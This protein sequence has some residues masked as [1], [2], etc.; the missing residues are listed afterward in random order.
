MLLKIACNKPE[1]LRSAAAHPVALA[2]DERPTTIAQN[3]LLHS[4]EKLDCGS[5]LPYQLLHLCFTQCEQ[6]CAT[7]SVRS[8]YCSALIRSSLIYKPPLCNERQKLAVSS[9]FSVLN[10]SFSSAV[11]RARTAVPVQ[12]STVGLQRIYHF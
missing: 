7:R 9:F 2:T 5:N 3:P 10:N 6:V 12:V 8:S 11:E 1:P 4:Q